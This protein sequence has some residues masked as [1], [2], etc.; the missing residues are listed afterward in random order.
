MTP[1]ETQI[2]QAKLT[3][4]QKEQSPRNEERRHT[5]AGIPH[6]SITAVGRGKIRR[7]DDMDRLV[8][9]Q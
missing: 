4:S 8:Q 7:N 6:R 2:Q 1:A 5:T 3:R 9:E